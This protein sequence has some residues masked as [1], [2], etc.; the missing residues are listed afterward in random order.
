VTTRHK[1]LLPA[2]YDGMLSAYAGALAGSPLADSSRARY[3]SRV[4]GFLAWTAGAAADGTVAGSPL[5]DLTAAARTAHLYHRR[6][7]DGGYAPATIDGALAAI[8]DFYARR[9]L[10]A[11]GAR[12]ERARP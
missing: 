1:V 11:T 12:R 9:G 4:Q 5:A 3:L 7:R 2:P 10:G 6:L 8:D